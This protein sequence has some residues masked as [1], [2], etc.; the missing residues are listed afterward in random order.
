MPKVVF[1]NHSSGDWQAV[2][3]DGKKVFEHHEME[4]SNLLDE[5][6]VKNESIYNA[7]HLADN[8][9][10]RNMYP[11]ELPANYAEPSTWK[12]PRQWGKDF[13]VEVMDPDG[14][15]VDGKDFSD[16]ISFEEYKARLWPSTIQSKGDGIQR[17]MQA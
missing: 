16:P 4:A 1:L 2:Y 7:D 13:D 9:D 3:I 10:G 17:L 6:D 14:W 15:R 12:T 11:K 8:L 5:L